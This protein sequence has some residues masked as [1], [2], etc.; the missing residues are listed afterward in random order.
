MAIGSTSGTAPAR[1]SDLFTNWSIIMWLTLEWLL[2]LIQQLLLTSY[3]LKVLSLAWTSG[4]YH[5]IVLLSKVNISSLSETEID[6]FYSLATPKVVVGF[7]TLASW[8][9][10]VPGQLEPFSTM[11]P[12]GS[13]DSAF[14][15]QSAPSVCVAIAR[16][17]HDDIS[18][19]TAP[20]LP[21]VP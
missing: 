11:L 9:H 13:T 8:L 10:Y 14:S 6:K 20:G 4:E 19:Q 1:L 15:L 12:L 2:D 18:L 17:K 5:S 3:A 16:W 21:I 7:L